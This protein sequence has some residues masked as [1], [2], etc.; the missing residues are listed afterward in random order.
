MKLF[1]PTDT[2]PCV[3][4]AD[5]VPI[6]VRILQNPLGSCSTLGSTI[7]NPCDIIVPAV[8]DNKHGILWL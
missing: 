2:K 7:T 4:K 1:S 6:F 8:H 5:L 3:T